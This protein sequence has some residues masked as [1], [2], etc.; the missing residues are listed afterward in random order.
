MRLDEF[1]EKTA[2]LPD[3]TELVFWMDE[4]ATWYEVVEHQELLPATPLHPYAVWVLEPGQGIE[5]DF[6]LAVRTGIDDGARLTDE[7]ED[8]GDW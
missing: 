3:D 4:D 7:T 2:G 1:R 6:D 8:D 5:K